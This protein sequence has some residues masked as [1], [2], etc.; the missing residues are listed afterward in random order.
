MASEGYPIAT[1]AAF[2]EGYLSSSNP[3]AYAYAA[4]RQT[5]SSRSTGSPVSRKPAAEKT[6][7]SPS[8]VLAANPGLRIPHTVPAPQ[9]DLPELTADVSFPGL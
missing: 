7:Q 5:A 3:K 1:T 4:I 8:K 6:W 9:A 2:D